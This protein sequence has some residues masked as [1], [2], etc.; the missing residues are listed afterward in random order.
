MSR[1]VI[2]GI[3][4]SRL[5]VLFFLASLLA[6]CATPTAAPAALA[7]PPTLTP[8]PTQTASATFAATPSATVKPLPSATATPLPPTATATVTLV[9]SLPFPPDDLWL[10]PADLRVHPDG[11]SF[12]SGDLISFQV[13]AHHGHDWSLSDPPDVDLEVWLGAPGEGELIVGD[14]VYFYGNQDGETWL[15]WAWDTTGLL[16]PQTLSVVLDPDDEVQIGDE[17]LENNLITRTIELRPRDEMPGA[18][19]DAHWVQQTSACCVFHYISGGAAERDIEALIALADEAI[20]Y[21][22]EQLG[23]ETDQVKLEV[24]L[25]NRVLGHGG[26]AGEELILSYLDRFYPGGEWIQVFRHEGTHALDR[27]FTQARPVLL[28]EGLAVHVA[29]GHFREEPITERAAALLALH[30]YIPLTEL[31]DDFYPSQHEVGYLEAAAFVSFLIDRFGWDT[32]KAFYSDIEENEAGQAAMI[33]A[34]LRDHFDLTLSQAEADWLAT[35]RALPLPTAQTFVSPPWHQPALH[36]TQCGTSGPPGQ[37]S[38]TMTDLCLTIDFYETVRRYQR[39]WDPS[40]YFLEVWLPAL[41]EAERR[42]ITADFV[43]HPAGPLNVT[44]ETMFVAADRALDAGEY[45]RT[46]A[47]L[48]AVNAV[49]DADGDLEADPLAAD[50]AALV[51]A[52]AAIGYQAQQ[53]DLDLGSDVARVIAA[54]EDGADTVEL[55]FAHRAGAWELASS[56]N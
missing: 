54:V 4:M 27:R 6:A 16:G 7:V 18:W 55:T 5:L 48:V 26:F 53:I 56:G 33:D 22:A 24:Y 2:L 38:R 31:A 50:Y 28:V 11:D 52:T 39:A 9:P 32:F 3:T 23:E 20:A 25:I 51:Q 41:E 21:A 14:R 49:L 35:L 12:Y 17:N 47:L 40:A 45:A 19:A 8:T 46:E 44:L 36:Q 34:A 10:G 37:V 30:L 29:G 13:Y 42:G 15:E 1:C 43:R